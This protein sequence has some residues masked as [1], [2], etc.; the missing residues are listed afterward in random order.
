MREMRLA[1]ISDSEESQFLDA[2]KKEK[3][4]SR[5]NFV[6]DGLNFDDLEVE[7]SSHGSEDSI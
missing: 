5:H 3:S 7:L 2:P 6:M 1:S 4:E